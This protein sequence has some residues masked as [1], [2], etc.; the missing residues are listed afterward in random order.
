ML[1][2]TPLI[3]VTIINKNAITWKYNLS[4]I[5]AVSDMMLAH[6]D[7]S[8]DINLFHQFYLILI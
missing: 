3:H 4:Q 6:T 5:S 7:S 8:N 2:T 1:G